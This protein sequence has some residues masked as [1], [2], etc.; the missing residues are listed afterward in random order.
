MN[1][2]GCVAAGVAAALFFALAA[3][4]QQRAASRESGEK[5]LRLSLLLSLMRRPLWLAGVGALVCGYG[6]QALALALGPV[7]IVQPLITI[8]LV[9]AVPIASLVRHGRPG[10]REWLAVMAVCGGVSLFLVV[11]DPASGTPN[12]SR[13]MWVLVTSAAGGAI[14]LAL[15]SAIGAGPRRRA[16]SLA[17]AAG[18][19]FAL[20][21]VLTKT[22]VSL[23][24]QGLGAALAGWQTYAVVGVGILGLLFSQSAYQAGPLT[25]SMPVVAVV[26]PTV[27]VVIGSTILD[28]R[29]RLGGGALLLE[30]LGALV[31]ATGV[32]L[33][34]TSRMVL[35]IYSFSG[36]RRGPSGGDEPG[37][38]RPRPG[39]N[40]PSNAAPP[41]RSSSTTMAE[42]ATTADRTSD[43]PVTAWN[44]RK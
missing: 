24:E 20:L 28:E 17:A 39:A 8:E 12:A 27:A 3:L 33:L 32:V 6:L 16:M 1:L 10:L 40:R 14:V 4:L 26:E 22:T 36:S 29:V 11:A 38:D 5:S 31:A 30:L 21:A 37:D 18:L 43:H 23:L 7:A 25:F 15:W 34:A 9:F 13:V 35:S 42:P 19:A 44:A 2:P 41:Q